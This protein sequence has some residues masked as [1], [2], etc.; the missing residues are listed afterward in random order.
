M[1]WLPLPLFP[2]GALTSSVITTAWIGI[3]VVAFFNLRLGWVLSGLVV[4]GYLVPLLLVKPWAAAVVLLEAVVTYLIVWLFSER[5]S[6]SGHWGSLFGRDRF[7]ALVLVSIMVRVLFDGWLLPQLGEWLNAQFHLQ[8]D[9]RNN[10]HSFGLIIISLIANQFWKSGL[11][12]GM[13]PLLVTVGTTYLIVRY[14]LMELTNFNISN[15]SYI[16]EDVAASIL[17]SPK[18]YIILLAAAFIASRMNLRYGW[19]FNGILIPA[20]LA[21]QWYQPMKILTSFVEAFII[22]LLARALLASP[23]FRQS[24]VEGARKLLLFFNIGFAYKLLL[25]YLLLWL[26]PDYKITDAYGFGYLLSTLMA[27]KMHDKDIV[28]RLTRATLQTSLTAVVLA[29]IL[30]FALTLLPDFVTQDSGPQAGGVA[31]ITELPDRALID[32]LREDKIRLYSSRA[33]DSLA[34]PLPAELGRFR[35]AIDDLLAHIAQADPQRLQRSA[36]LLDGLNYELILLQQRYYY[37]REREPMRGWG[38]YVLD[39]QTDKRLLLAIP[40]PLDERGTV[41]A[42]SWLFDILQARALAIA[43]SQRLARLDASTDVLLNRQTVFHAF[44]EAM[45]RRDILQLRG[46]R[47]ENLPSRGGDKTVL[48]SHLWVK[49]SLPP[50]LSL[51]RMEGLLDD[52]DISWDSP[53]EVNRLRD[54]SLDQFAEL[55]LTQDDARSMLARRLVSDELVNFQQGTQRIDGYLQEWLLASKARIAE[56]GTEAYVVPKLEEL[57]FFDEEVIT[58]LL[59]VAQHQFRFGRW[60]HEGISQLNSLAANAKVLNYNLTHYHHA[61]SDEHYLLLTEDETGDKRHWGTYVFRLGPSQGYLVQS[62]RPI[63]EINS[64]E[65][66]VAL[67]EQLD[68]RALMI[69]G[70][71]PDTNLDGSA[72]L[73]RMDNIRSLF[74]LISQVVLRESGDEPMM[75]IHSRA[76]GQRV[77]TPLPTED[78]LISLNG[79]TRSKLQ[80]S[81]LVRRLLDTLEGKGIRYRFVDGGLGTSGYEIGSIPQSMYTQIAD[82][83]EFGLLWLS[84]ITRSSYRQQTENYLEAAQFKLLGVE[85]LESSLFQELHERDIRDNRHIPDELRDTLAYYL[86]TQDIITLQRLVMGW[87]FD[88]RFLR[89]V[90]RDSRQS[91]LLLSDHQDRVLL[92]VN[93]SPRQFKKHHHVWVGRL[94]VAQ[95]DDFIDNRAAWLEVRDL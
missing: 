61:Q 83:K 17:A 70:A 46:Y 93:L 68:A 3:F 58:P 86:A 37:L 50:G 21:L 57:L 39:S 13:G 64:F 44:H 11:R 47:Q 22:L 35:Q 53:G 56:R 88:F 42:G 41:D 48:K 40:A 7:F 54:L 14:G 82:N 79:G 45:G 20:L 24:S 8:L 69:A 16:Y 55:Y 1:E 33:D 75:V 72:D 49:R 94:T 36:R 6:R 51:S 66:A 74:T 26:A 85:T 43:G 63:Y 38:I 81:P 67:F 71:H 77:D 29:S 30:G 62:P 95:V 19:D 28:A 32:Q 91:F 9:Y 31:R 34:A 12:K 76:F 23:L 27:I 60:T 78:M 5:L 59:D 2:Q 80:A 10:L 89:L 4:P 15:L 18:A 73:V 92:A 25:G 65:Y 90:D 52:F 84:P 87:Q